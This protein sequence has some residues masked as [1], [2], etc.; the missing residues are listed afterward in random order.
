[1]TLVDYAIV[2]ASAFAAGA[3][4]SVAGGGT[5]LTYP[6]LDL[7]VKLD[8]LQANATSTMG[9]WPAS[10]SGMMGYRS[11]LAD[12]KH[13]PVD[14]GLVSVVGGCVGAFLLKLLGTDIFRMLVPWLIVSAAVLFVTQE[15][16]M[17][18]I[19]G[20]AEPVPRDPDAPTPPSLLFY[21]FLVAVYGGYFGA[22][23]GILMLAALGFMRLGDIYRMNFL[24]NFCALAINVAATLIFVYKG[25]INW[26]VALVMAAAAVFGGY[27]GADVAKKIGARR[28][29]WTISA[30]GISMAAWMLYRFYAK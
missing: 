1:V 3:I 12:R 29:R 11:A 17:K 18:R 26:P 7:I 4:N 16:L 25:L 5:L 22:G 15:A 19:H 28:L 2:F 14:F 6:V 10:L 27:A 13:F 30:I 8:P 20:G 21:Q 9:L 24:K 23:I